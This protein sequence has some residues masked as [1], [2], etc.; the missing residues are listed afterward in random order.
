MNILNEKGETYKSKLINNLPN[1]EVFQ[2]NKKISSNDIWFRPKIDK[3]ILKELSTRKSFPGLL[4]ILTYFIA[5]ILSGYLALLSWG[6]YWTILFFWIYGTIYVFSSAFEHEC[7]HRTFFKERWLNDYFQYFLSFM[8]FREP[9]VMRWTHALH[10]S[11]TLKTHDPYDFEIQVDRPSKLFHFYMSLVP[12]GQLLWIHESLFFQTL[13]CSFNVI[14]Y[15]VKQTVP[16]DHL[17]KLKFNSR[18]HVLF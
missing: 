16:D 5:L 11:Y 13:K 12:F 14:P 6:S 1:S 7:R 3:K 15:P 18:I 9:V 2:D 4:S 10:H 8:T 17:W